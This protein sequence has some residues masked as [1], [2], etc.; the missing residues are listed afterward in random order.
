MSEDK[1]TE[2]EMLDVKIPCVFCGERLGKLE[3]LKH[4]CWSKK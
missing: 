2:K 4:N 1:P 3:K